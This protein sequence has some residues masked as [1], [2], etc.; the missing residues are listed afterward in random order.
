MFVTANQIYVFIACVAFGSVSGIFYSLSSAF[1]FFIKNKVIKIVFDIFA[2]IVVSFLYVI[3]SVLIKF[4]NVR[5]YMLVGV[6][7]GLILYFKSFHILLAKC[8]KK[9]YNIIYK[10]YKAK[11]SNGKKQKSII[12]R[13]N[14]KVGRCRNGRGSVAC[15]NITV[16]DDL[17]THIYSS[18][19]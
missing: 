6:F 14:K 10:Y 2:S 5:I 16:R 17:S 9:I 8:A 1:K 15:R 11:I 3:F 4:P 12:R 19:Q 13:K 7:V 18:L